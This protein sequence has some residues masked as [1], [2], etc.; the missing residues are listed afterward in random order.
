MLDPQT[1][2]L[3]RQFGIDPGDLQ[4]LAL[5]SMLLITLTLLTAIPTAAIAKSKGRSRGWW[6]LFA[7]SIPV[8]PLLLVWFLPPVDDKTEE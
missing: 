6:L 4:S 2:E 7:L 8:I 3:L 1:M 5:G